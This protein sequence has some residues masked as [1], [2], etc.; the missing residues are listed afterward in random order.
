MTDR[1]YAAELA[2]PP[3]PT[4]AFRAGMTRRSTLALTVTLVLAAA[5]WVIAIRLMDSTGMGG[6]G[7][8][9]GMAAGPAT[10]LG[11]VGLFAAAWIS[12]MAAMMLPGAALPVAARVQAGSSA[13]V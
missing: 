12:M 9:D 13:T 1:A 11:S 6:M 2:L 10:E 5:A 8:M 7:G 3:V 4:K